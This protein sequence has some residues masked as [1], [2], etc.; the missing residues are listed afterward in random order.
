VYMCGCV[1]VYVCMSYC[2]K[3]PFL[4]VVLNKGVLCVCVCVRMCGYVCVYVHVC[5][6]GKHMGASIPYIRTY[7]TYTHICKSHIHTGICTW[8]AHTCQGC[9]TA[10]TWTHLHYTYIHTYIHVCIH[11]YI[12]THTHMYISHTHRY[13]HLECSQMSRMPHGKHMDAFISGPLRRPL[14]F[15][16][17]WKGL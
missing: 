9:R 1:M 4:G 13:M 5:L 3:E 2:I 6:H 8:S 17:I 7:I 11:T 12:Y 14:I 15:M 10:S 16:G